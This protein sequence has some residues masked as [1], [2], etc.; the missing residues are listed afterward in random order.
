MADGIPD[1]AADYKPGDF[2]EV[3]G[4]PVELLHREGSLWRAARIF[5]KSDSPRTVLVDESLFVS[6]GEV[7][8]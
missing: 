5:P 2:V 4:M 7:Q 6:F 1:N 3:G 8:P